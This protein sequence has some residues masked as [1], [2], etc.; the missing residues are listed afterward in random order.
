MQYAMQL[1][2]VGM[3]M[4]IIYTAYVQISSHLM[5]PYIESDVHE[6]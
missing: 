4:R 5:N 2:H 3:G 1:E 6:I